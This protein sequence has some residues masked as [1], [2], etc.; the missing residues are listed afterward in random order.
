[1]VTASQVCWLLYDA[2]GTL[3]PAVA[4][5][6]FPVAEVFRGMAE[7]YLFAAGVAQFLVIRH[8]RRAAG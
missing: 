3:A 2:A 7:T 8:V 1:L 4:P 5:G 6:G